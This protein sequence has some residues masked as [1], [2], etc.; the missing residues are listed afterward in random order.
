M[1]KFRGYT[2]SIFDS[3]PTVSRTMALTD[4][5]LETCNT[6][7]NSCV[8]YIEDENPFN[9]GF[10]CETLGSEETDVLEFHHER[11]RDKAQ[12]TL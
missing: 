5:D 1:A 12:R 3:P 2:G 7:K 4:H 9:E 8:S 10:S 11:P 6:M